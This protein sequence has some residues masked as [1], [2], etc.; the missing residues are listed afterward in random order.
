MDKSQSLVL[1]IKGKNRNIQLLCHMPAV[2]G[3][4]LDSLTKCIPIRL[5]PENN[6]TTIFI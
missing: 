1:Y 4:L 6:Y 3:F 5:F 2:F